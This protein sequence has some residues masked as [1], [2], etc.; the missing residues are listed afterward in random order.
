MKSFGIPSYTLVVKTM[1]TVSNIIR[2][3]N[4]VKNPVDPRVEA[5]RIARHEEACRDI[6]SAVRDLEALSPVRKVGAQRAEIQAELA[7]FKIA[8]VVPVPAPALAPSLGDALLLR[9]AKVKR[10]Q[11]NTNCNGNLIDLDMLTK[12]FYAEDVHSPERYEDLNR[13]LKGFEELF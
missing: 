6:G 2:S 12:A 10:Y 8:P 11:E 4:E 3:F 9:V 1:K 13:F 5:I 7:A